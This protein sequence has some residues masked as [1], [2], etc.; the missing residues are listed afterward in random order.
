MPGEVDAVVVGD[1]DAQRPVGVGHL[2]ALR[3]RDVV[4]VDDVAPV[5][6]EH[7]GAPL[8]H[9]V[10][11]AGYFRRS[12]A[13]DQLADHVAVTADR[14]RRVGGVDEREH[15]RRRRCPRRGRRAPRCRDRCVSASG[16]RV[17]MQ[18]RYG[19]ESRR[20][21]PTIG[22]RRRDPLGLR[23]DRAGRAA[24]PRR[25]PRRACRRRRGARRS[26][27]NFFMPCARPRGRGRGDTS[28][29]QQRSPPATTRTT[30][31]SSSASRADVVR[32]HRE[33][34]TALGPAAPVGVLHRERSRRA[35][36][37]VC[38]FGHGASLHPP[39]AVSTSAAS[40]TAIPRGRRR[41]GAADGVVIRGARAADRG[42]GSFT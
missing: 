39:S 5:A 34:L 10:V 40:A 20:V 16:S 32:G 4:R 36:R 8:G 1:Q 24:A 15:R 31:T 22:E 30:S 28:A 18:R 29:R 6:R 9:A 17:S 11:V 26:T 33:V 12:S 23:R 27:A 2:V 41:L 7:P 37:G 3:D 25:R 35:G 42:T 21:I 14:D 13:L 38:P 19:L